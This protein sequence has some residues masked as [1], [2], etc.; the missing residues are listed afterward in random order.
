VLPKWIEELRESYEGDVW[1]QEVLKGAVDANM[2]GKLSTHLGVIRYKDR[3]Y[4]GPDGGA[5]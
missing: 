3:F 5:K 4:V 1:A 2:Q